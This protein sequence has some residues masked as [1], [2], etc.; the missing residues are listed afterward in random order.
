MNEHDIIALGLGI[1]PPW[2]I[3]GQILDT[4]KSPHELRIR[5]KAD[6]GAQY[7]CPVCGKMCKAHDF[8][9]KTWRH[10]NFFQHHCYITAKIPRT[11]CPDHGVKTV[12]VPWARKGSKFTLLFEQ[13]ALMLV[14]HMPVGPAARHMGITDNSLWRIVFHYV[15]KAME[16]LDLSFV[17]RIAVDETASGKWHR[18]VTVFIDLDRGKRSVIFATPGKG[19]ET[20]SAFC[21]HL[22]SHG[23]CPENLTVAVCDMSKAFISGIEE[24]FPNSETV[25]DWFHVVKQFN[26][27]LDQ[28][29]RKESRQ[30]SMPS[31]VRW[32]VLKAADG[33]LTEHQKALLAELEDFA[34]D[35]A[36]AWRIKEMLRWVNTAATSQAA[37]WRLSRFIN[38]ASDLIKGNSNL[39]PVQ[40]ALKTVERHRD[41]ILARWGN[42]YT[43][44]RLE[45]LNGLFQAARAR[46]RGYRNI[47]TFIT[48]IYLIAAP[49]EHIL[50][51]T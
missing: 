18:Y 7:P 21:R 8:Q 44:A 41:R 27:A 51:S 1:T 15:D 32:A 6:R 20:I 10:L 12:K 23:G 39:T 11:R 24:S 47:N 48:M 50:K 29:R 40:K 45:S 9:E 14:R 38:F 5:I 26:T 3:V 33:E 25:V 43:N 19:K 49:I 16:G 22:K 2:R 35:T 34:K 36:V 46:A 17:H 37:C 13:A 42:D 28:V 4:N 30:G 31:G